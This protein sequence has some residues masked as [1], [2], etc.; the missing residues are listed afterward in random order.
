MGLRAVDNADLKLLE[1]RVLGDWKVLKLCR[2]RGSERDVA[3][4]R[5]LADM[6]GNE[7]AVAPLCHS[8]VSAT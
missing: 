7:H 3:V 1:L 4:R 6:V 5:M 8:R 2:D